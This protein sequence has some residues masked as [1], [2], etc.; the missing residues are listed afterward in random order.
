MA[1]IRVKNWQ[2]QR[3]M[4]Y[5][6]EEVKP[7]KQFAAVFDINKCIACQTCTMACKHT[8]TGGLGQEYMWWNNV[9]TKPYGFYPL[10]WDVKILEMLGPQ[11][12]DGNKYAGKTI[13]EAAPKGEV[14]AG[15]IPDEMDWAY[16]NIGEDEPFGSIDKGEHITIPHKVW[17]FYLPR[18]C[19]HC[20]YPACL[21]ACPR[22]AIYKR[23]EDGIVLIDQKRCRGYR[24]C[25]RA[26]PYKKAL[27]NPETKISEKCIACYPLVEQGVQNQCITTC[28]GRIRLAGW[29]SPPEKADPSNPMDYLVHI[30][31][32]ALPLY[33]QLG[34]EP[35]VYYIPPVHVPPKYLKQMFGPGVDN[36][37]KTYGTAHTDPLLLGALTIFGSTDKWVA[38]FKIEKEQAIA[39]DSKGKEIVRVPLKEPVFI[40]PFRDE[41]V[42]AFRHNI[43]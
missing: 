40:R 13:F 22:K 21:A 38:R 6:Y 5:P 32:I 9:E 11:R 19:N 29:V 24:D 14:S 28:I 36:A 34:L 31:K 35:N 30:K 37:I 1:K 25:V 7:K 15:Y 2:I 8:W 39:Y 10:A 26:C 16:P 42:E 41:K 18:I 27:F 33:P 3:E 12:W 43:T 4:I 20:S 17:H 23:Q